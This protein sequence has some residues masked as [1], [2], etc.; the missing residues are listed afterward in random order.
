[1]GYKTQNADQQGTA[2]ALLWIK[3]SEIMKTINNEFSGG[4]KR[5]IRRTFFIPLMGI[6]VTYHYVTIISPLVY[7]YTIKMT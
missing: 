5:I 4:K 1:M 6:W 2:S 7:N 3:S